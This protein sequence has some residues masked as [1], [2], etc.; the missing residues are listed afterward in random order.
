MCAGSH[1][2]G[3]LQ[4]HERSLDSDLL[5]LLLRDTLADNPHL[6][7]VLMSA[8]ANAAEFARY[9][10]AALRDAPTAG[11]AVNDAA[12][13]DIPGFTYPVRELSLEDVLQDSGAQ[14][15]RMSGQF[16]ALVGCRS[17]VFLESN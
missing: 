5:M 11:G 2:Q 9:F 17:V 4:V 3:W 10:D 8:T 16:S 7:L 13:I 12:V 1:G 15:L 6:R 14:C